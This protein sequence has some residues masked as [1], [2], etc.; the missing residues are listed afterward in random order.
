MIKRIKNKINEIKIALALGMSTV[1][2]DI[3]A[4]NFTKAPE[5]SAMINPKYSNNDFLRNYQLG[6]L[7]EEQI[8]RFYFTLDAMDHIHTRTRIEWKEEEVEMLDNQG[9]PVYKD[10]VLQTV[11]EMIP[12]SVPMSVDEIKAQDLAKQ[13]LGDP[14]EGYQTILLISNKNILLKD[15]NPFTKEEAVYQPT[16]I[17]DRGE[18]DRRGIIKIEDF[19]EEVFVKALEDQDH[20]KNRNYILEFYCKNYSIKQK[21]GENDKGIMYEEEYQPDV[22]FNKIHEGLNLN[23]F[24]EMDGVVLIQTTAT[25][26][27]IIHSYKVNSFLEIKKVKHGFVVKFNVEKI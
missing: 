21:Q 23:Y 19:C 7:N 6:K 14:I 27:D 26:N 20:E 10:G 24:I 1:D 8:K 22:V 17:I 12:Y 25:R 9:Q 16:L 4:G 11:M 3:M 13:N 18:V 2:K 5:G 15:Y